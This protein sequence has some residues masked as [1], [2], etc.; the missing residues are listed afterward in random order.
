[1]EN[2]RWVVGPDGPTCNSHDRQVVVTDVI[3][4]VE[5]RR[6]GRNHVGPSGL[7]FFCGNYDP[8]LTVGATTSRRFAPFTRVPPELHIELKDELSVLTGSNDSHNQA[9]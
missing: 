7:K 3:N 6:T 8:D 1:M 4:D 5:V 2:S 9:I